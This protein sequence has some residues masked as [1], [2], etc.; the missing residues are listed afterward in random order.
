MITLKNITKAYQTRSENTTVL[1][2]ISLTIEAH[3]LTSI[4]GPSGAGKTTLLQV[5]G[6]LDPPTSGGLWIDGVNIHKLSEKEKFHLRQHKISYIFQQFQLLPALTAI[7]N[8]MLP[9]LQF[10]K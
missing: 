10:K 9:V 8:V 5:M 4:I 6:L 1:E 2:D 7:E 3:S